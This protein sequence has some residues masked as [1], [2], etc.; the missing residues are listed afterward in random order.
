M[1][2]ELYEDDRDFIIGLLRNTHLMGLRKN[3]REAMTNPE[4]NEMILCELSQT[5]AEELVGQLS[6]E[7]NHNRRKSVS[8]RADSIADSIEAQ[9][10]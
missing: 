9:F 6:F 1:L 4:C 5:D 2:L 7:A 3:F 8:E 10:G